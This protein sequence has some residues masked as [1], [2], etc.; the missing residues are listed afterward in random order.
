MTNEKLKEALGDK[1][2]D[3][4]ALTADPAGASDGQGD[5]IDLDAVSGGVLDSGG[6]PG[7]T[8][9]VYN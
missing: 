5:E 3:H 6:C 9:Q 4:Q 2:I 8:C 7:M 1:A